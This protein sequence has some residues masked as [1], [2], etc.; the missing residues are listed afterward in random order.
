MNLQIVKEE[1]DR[2]GFVKIEKFYDPIEEIQPIQRGIWK[3][4]GILLRKYDI[5]HEQ[6]AFDPLSFDDGYQDLIKADRRY[7]GEVYDAI[8]QI[9]EFMQ[10]V[11]SDRNRSLFSKLRETDL[12]G[13]AAAGYGIRIDN[14]HE[15]AYRS[16]WH[17][18][19]RDQ[20][21]SVDGLVYW[22]P[23]IPITPEIGPVN[24]CP[25]SHRDGLR[26]SYRDDSGQSGAYALRIENEEEVIT[27]FGVEAP[28]S[29][30]GDLLLIDF[31]TLH[32]SGVNDSSRSRWSMQFRYFN[33]NH[34]SGIKLNWS[35]G[36]AQGVKIEDVHPELFIPNPK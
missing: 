11:S 16:H 27:K 5:P 33:F 26:R 14:P 10:L 20:L 28:L 6:Q 9:P 34:E 12:P 21:R 13:L 25:G 4:L 31:L 8:K 1:L 32:A 7:G 24:I 17:Y 23:L 36:A 29:K 18:E 15:E 35:P 30:P 2:Q 19:Y 22:T 3:I